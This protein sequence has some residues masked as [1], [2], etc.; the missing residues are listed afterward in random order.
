ME[1]I[2]TAIIGLDTSHATAFPGL[3]LDPATKP[4][5]KID[6]LQ[7]TRCLRFDTPFQKPEGLDKRQAYLESLGVEVGTDFDWAVEG[8][9]AI[10][11]AINDPSLH[12]E[13]F[14]KCAPLGKP[15]FLDKPVADTV[16]NARKIEAIAKKYNT[17]FFSAS[18][19]RFSVDLVEALEQNIP[20]QNAMVWGPV[21]V[22]ASGSS[23]VWYGVHAFEMLERIMGPGAQ[24]VSVINDERG[25]VC[26]V[27]YPDGRRGIVELTRKVGHY[28]ALMR[29]DDGEAIMAKVSGRVPIYVSL[30]RVIEKFF[31]GTDPVGV[32]FNESMEIMKM[33]EAAD[34]ASQSGKTV[35]LN[36]I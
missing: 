33:L 23:I 1:K 10:I 5:F 34:L 3:M 19:L 11:I 28:G 18:S 16:A 12:L 6:S 17:R 30:I 26:T 27:A 9:D 7:P 14:E 24:S 32:D 31:K 21:G 29:N 20:V 25:H 8:C 2:K 35:Y 13:Y 36:D 22:A 15:I 4:E